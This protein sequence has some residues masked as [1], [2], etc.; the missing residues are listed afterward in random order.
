[1]AK[2]AYRTGFALHTCWFFC[3]F[4]PASPSYQTF[5]T[6]STAESSELCGHAKP[7]TH[8]KLCWWWCVLTRPDWYSATWDVDRKSTWLAVVLHV[9]LLPSTNH[10]KLAQ[11][12]KPF[13]DRK[14]K[15]KSVQTPSCTEIKQNTR[16]KNTH[17]RTTLKELKGRKNNAPSKHSCDLLLNALK[18]HVFFW[19]IHLVFD[20]VWHCLKLVGPSRVFLALSLHELLFACL[21]TALAFQAETG[22]LTCPVCTLTLQHRGMEPPRAI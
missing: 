10:Y 17:K 9:I 1:M 15:R 2:H 16:S 6:H 4:L 11:Q 7:A 21:S 8:H 3:R 13:M 18:L 5:F 22:S 19:T 20:Y 12:P 14:S